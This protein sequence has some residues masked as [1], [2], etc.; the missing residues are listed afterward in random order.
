MPQ[1]QQYQH[2]NH[3]HHHQTPVYGQYTADYANNNGHHVAHVSYGLNGSSGVGGV[4]A[5]YSSVSRQPQPHSQQHQQQ[6]Y[7]SNQQLQYYQPT[8]AAYYGN[9]GANST[10]TRNG[11]GLQLGG[12]LDQQHHHH[13]HHQQQQQQLQLHQQ[14]YAK[15]NN[16]AVVAHHARQPQRTC[17]AD[18]KVQ[19]WLKKC[20]FDEYT[21]LFVQAG[22]DMPT[23]SRMTPE[24]LTAIGITKPAHRRKLIAHIQKLNIDD[25]IPN[26]RPV[27]L[28]PSL[29]LPLFLSLFEI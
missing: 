14:S 15:S 10:L 26:H 24:D 13:P 6:Q 4:G 8:T 9:C 2:S 1:Q 11:G 29:S 25:G 27:S 17:D 12:N 7:Q 18:M 20:D 19:Q 3:V 5:V 22:Y 16:C 21:T 28:S 23:L